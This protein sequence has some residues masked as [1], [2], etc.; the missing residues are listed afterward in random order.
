MDLTNKIPI[1]V[2]AHSKLNLPFD[3][4]ST[5]MFML[6]Q[7]MFYRHC[8]RTERL[9]CNFTSVV[10][11]NPLVVP[12][13]GRIRQNLRHFFVPYRLIFP[14]WDEFIGDVVAS[15]FDNSSQVVG[16]PTFSTDVALTLFESSQY[17]TTVSSNTPY[18]FVHNGTYYKF[19]R[20]G[21]NAYKVF[22]SLGY[23]LLPD[24]KTFMFNA[25]ALL[26]YAKI[27]CDW[28]CNSQYLNDVFYLRLQRLFKFNDPSSSLS[29]TQQDLSDIFTFI[30][31]AVYDSNPYF[32]DAWDNPV[33]PNSGQFTQFAFADPT[34]NNGSYVTTLSNGT[35]EMMAAPNTDSLG[36]KYL[37]DALQKLSIYQRR[38]ALSGARAIDRVLA[39]YGIQTDNLKSQRSIY[40]GVTTQNVDINSIFATA[41]GS[42]S[43]GDSVVGD[44]AGAGFGAGNGQIDF[45][46][47]ED[48]IFI[49]IS[50]IIPSGGYFQ[51][52]DRNNRHLT[53]E[54]FFIP[55]FD[56]LGVQSI[57]KGEVYVSKN[58]DSFASDAS[59]YARHFGFT[60]RY[61]EYKRPISRVSGDFGVSSVLVGSDAWHLM[62]KFN[63]TYFNNSVNN[64]VH[65]QDFAR[66]TDGEQYMRLFT[67]T[68]YEIDPFNLFLHVDCVAFAPCHNLVDSFD[69]DLDSAK[70]AI[71]SN[72]PK[73]N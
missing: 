24:S 47:D 35:P 72:G 21:R 27:Y 57:E 53:K 58:F 7:P 56:S 15:N 45:T 52:Y 4:V 33:S 55:D 2:D 70:V 20:F 11:P 64:I 19:T 26:A 46:T 37:H 67:Y 25:L 73:M 71:D 66:G 8:L 65:S 36:S 13:F 50:T 61:G 22:Y 38:H 68:E 9:Q 59:D 10:R 16:V 32:E 62:R 30:R 29:L 40:L 41:N 23:E 43:Q 31:P 17:S 54:Q 14:N 1:A 34:S 39:E 51:G 49:T 5:G 18:D 42:N 3:H 69:W 63:D 28:Y 60:S 44:Y 6:L 48:G 12:T